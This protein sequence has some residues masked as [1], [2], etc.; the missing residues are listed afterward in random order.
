MTP[1]FF[2]VLGDLLRDR[3]AYLSDVRALERR[4]ATH[5]S[6]G[7]VSDLSERLDTLEE[8]FRRLTLIA[9]SLCEACVRQGAVSREQLQAATASLD[10]L[11]GKLDGQLDPRSIWPASRPPKPPTPDEFLRDLEQRP[12]G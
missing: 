3:R 8:D 5:E 9:L 11:D 12:E 6:H 1:D 4:V 7:S 2:D 10:Q